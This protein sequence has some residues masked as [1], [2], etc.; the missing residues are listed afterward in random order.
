ME[1]KEGDYC[2]YMLRLWWG[3]GAHRHIARASLEDVM[4]NEVQYFK[5]LAALIDYLEGS[6]TVSRILSTAVDIG[7]KQR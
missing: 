6:V 5:S 4:T 7:E 3:K 2:S 1:S